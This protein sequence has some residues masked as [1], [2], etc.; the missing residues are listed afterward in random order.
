MLLRGAAFVPPGYTSLLFAHLYEPS[1]CP[2]P[3]PLFTGF[4]R[5]VLEPMGV[6]P[7]PA[8][9]AAFAK[10]P[11]RVVLVSRRPGPG[12]RHLARQMAN[13]AEVVG[14]LEGMERGEGPRGG[15]ARGGAHQR[16]RWRQQQQ[17]EQQ[18]LDLQLMQRQ[19]QQQHGGQ[20]GDANLQ[21]A[22]RQQRQQGG[23]LGRHQDLDEQQQQQ[24]A[25]E[26]AAGYAQVSPSP[27]PSSSSSSS[28]S[29]A[30]ATSGGSGQQPL[31]PISVR[32]VDLA[33]MS[34]EEQL[35]LLAGGGTDVLIGMHGAALAWAL[36]LPPHAAVIELWPQA[37]GVWRCYEHF[38]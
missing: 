18:G 12:K 23:Q 2:R 20:G 8:A 24:Q 28:S 31:P 17:Q 22:A 35:N 13:E 25:V 37:E 32:V 16:Q 36:L 7:P 27:R 3:T 33:A 21:G 14:M 29:S 38:R 30:A 15:G 11:L 6:L 4:R 9:L 1:S 10:A 5:F 19:R 26:G 34:L